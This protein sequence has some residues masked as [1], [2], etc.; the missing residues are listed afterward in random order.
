[1]P[2]FCISYTMNCNF[3]SSK[4]VPYQR[5]WPLQINGPLYFI[6]ISERKKERKRT[7]CKWNPPVLTYKAR[8][9][10]LIYRPSWYHDSSA[11]RSHASN[12]KPTEDA[13]HKIFMNTIVHDLNSFQFLYFKR[14][15]TELLKMK[16]L[17]AK[18]TTI[19]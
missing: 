10:T 4:N 16:N 15:A 5:S 14:T 2:P 12:F 18:P 1:M 3:N 11:L 6:S 7:S 17:M 13:T 9:P 19:L 8:W